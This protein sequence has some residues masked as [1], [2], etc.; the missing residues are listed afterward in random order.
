[1]VEINIDIHKT[2]ISLGW[3]NVDGACKELAGKLRPQGFE[4]MLVVPRGGVIPG[5]MLAYYM[6]LSSIEYCKAEVLCN[7]MD[8]GAALFLDQL[9]HLGSRLLVVDDICDTGKTFKALRGVLPMAVYCAP[10]VKSAGK[11]WCDFHEHQFDDS[12]WIHFPWEPP[13]PVT[14]IA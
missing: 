12:Q 13:V 5:G 8:L 2:V 7:P 6:G 11:G 1:M 9:S 3:D 14:V 4:H 10:F